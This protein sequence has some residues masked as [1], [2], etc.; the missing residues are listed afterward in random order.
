MEKQKPLYWRLT[1]AGAA[2]AGVL[3]LTACSREPVD[4]EG[5]GS[6]FVVR[7]RVSDAESDGL[8][9]LHEEKLVVVSASGK[10]ATWFPD[11]GG[12]RPWSHEYD[13]LQ[14]YSKESDGFFDG[15]GKDVK[16][17]EVYSLQ[18]EEIEPQQLKPGTIVEIQGRI[19]ESRYRHRA[20]KS[21]Y[22]DERDLAVYDSVRVVN[23]P[24]Q[25]VS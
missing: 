13:F 5:V 3:A 4:Y 20:G 21:S 17:G 8:V 22:C 10:A 12:Y 19:R 2:L 24:L 25:P 18:G 7:G 16:V 6:E 11:H 9:Q 15:C 14:K 23:G 1:A